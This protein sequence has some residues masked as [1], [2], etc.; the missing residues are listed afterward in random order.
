M[1]AVGGRRIWV[2][3]SSAH[4]VKA[5]IYGVST[6]LVRVETHGSLGNLPALC[7]A[8]R[9][10]AVEVLRIGELVRAGLL[11]Q[12]AVGFAVRTADRVAPGTCFRTRR[13]FTGRESLLRVKEP[14]ID[15]VTGLVAR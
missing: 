10:A 6:K 1:R 9:Q 8:S 13:G 2:R 12:D 11:H 3:R 4:V 14:A 7:D 15:C 5:A